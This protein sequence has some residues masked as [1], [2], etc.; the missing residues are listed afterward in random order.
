MKE[1]NETKTNSM[2]VQAETQGEITYGITGIASDLEVVVDGNVV[3]A[4]ITLYVNGVKRDV[5]Y[6]KEIDPTEW[7]VHWNLAL[8]PNTGE[9]LE[10][11]VNFP[12]NCIVL[13]N[14]LY[15]I[16]TGEI[17]KDEYY[18]DL[19]YKKEWIGT[20]GTEPGLVKNGG[21]V[22]ISS[23]GTMNYNSNVT[24]GEGEW[25]PV[26]TEAAVEGL[27]SSK[28]FKYTRIGNVVHCYGYC[29]LN[30]DAVEDNL[31]TFDEVTPLSFTGLP[32]TVNSFNRKG[33]HSGTFSAY[34]AAPLWKLQGT[35]R[36]CIH[37]AADRFIMSSAAKKAFLDDDTFSMDFTYIL[38]E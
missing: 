14:M 8:D 33:Y 32:F 19:F 9:F 2:A 4:G 15:I 27:M 13:F 26:F 37:P 16:D 12:S 5:E 17:R 38:S 29:S 3:V 11:Y 10:N 18:K 22:I 1:I 20:G 30:C 24:Y 34:E 36:V 28:N 25:N 31:V 23:D 35:Q 6:E 7:A 21:N